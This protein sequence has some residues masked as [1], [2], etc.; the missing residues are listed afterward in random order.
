MLKK[1]YLHIII[2]I[3]LI[4]IAWTISFYFHCNNK[5]QAI[6]KLLDS[7]LSKEPQR[8]FY[9]VTPGP[10]YLNKKYGFSMTIPSDKFILEEK[11]SNLAG[12]NIL[13]I[14]ENSKENFKDI[15][16]ENNPGIGGVFYFNMF[17]VPK[18][19]ES[20]L[21]L[22]ENLKKLEQM[23]QKGFVEKKEFLISGNKKVN[24]YLTSKKNEAWPASLDMFLP[25]A[26]AF[27]EDKNNAYYFSSI[28]HYDDS[29]EERQSHIDIM[30]EIIRSIKFDN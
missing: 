19:D 22:K 15:L 8:E 2:A 20:S 18:L 24:F 29:V 28:S 27:F 6:K 10:Q 1:Y 13:L 21:N 14:D 23:S 4:S 12:D 16:L 17:I 9:I 3:I 30:E 11:F 5:E 7:T 25:E 26:T